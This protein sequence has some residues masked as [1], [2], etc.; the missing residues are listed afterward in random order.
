MRDDL[1]ELFEER[2][3][4]LEADGIGQTPEIRK[5]LAWTDTLRVMFYDPY[6]GKCAYRL[7]NP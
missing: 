7:R 4:I 2:L 5:R 3:A 1:N 6:R